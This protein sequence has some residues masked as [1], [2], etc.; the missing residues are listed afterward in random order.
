MVHLS[1]RNAA[2][3]IFAPNIAQAHVINHLKGEEAKGQTRNVLEE[4][5]RID[6][7][8]ISIRSTQT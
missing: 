4:T 3:Q 8:S 1:R 7:R 6:W 2:C 5:A